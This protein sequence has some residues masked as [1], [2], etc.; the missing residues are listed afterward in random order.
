MWDLPRP[1]LEPVSSALAGRFSTTPPP[2]KPLDRYLTP[3]TKINSKWIK[4][5][6]VKPENIKL[7]EE[8]IGKKLLDICLGDEFLDI[9]PKSTGNKSKIN[10]WDYIKVKSFFTEETINK[11]K[12][13]PMEWEKIFANHISDMGFISKI[14]KKLNSKKPPQKTQ[15]IRFFKGAGLP[16]WLSG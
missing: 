3:L 9:T 14:Y 15:I 8:N 16:W 1:G 10:K 2:G 7:R 12:R 6:N 4:D 11:M 13:Q 5:L